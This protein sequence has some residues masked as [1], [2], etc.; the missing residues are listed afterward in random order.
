ML[1]AGG[2][3][4]FTFAVGSTR[5]SVN[6]QHNFWL[7][8]ILTSGAVTSLILHY[9]DGAQATYG[10]YDKSDTSFGG[11]FYVTSMA[12]AAGNQTTF[13]YDLNFHLTTVTAAD[14]TT[15]TLS[16]ND[17]I[18]SDAITSIGTSYG[19]SVSFSY[20]DLYGPILTNITD[21]AGLS[22][23]IVYEDVAGHSVKKLITPYGTTYLSTFGSGGAYGVFDRTVNIT[24]ATGSQEFYGQIN[25]YSVFGTDWPGWATS[26]IPTNTP[27]GTL[28]KESTNRVE[29]NT[30]Y[31]NAQQFVP[32]INTSLGSFNWAA[33]KCSRIRHWL[34]ATDPTY[35]HW[36]TL[37]VEQAPSPDGGTTEGQTTWYD[38]VGKPTGV[39]Y[40]RGTQML[41]SVAARVMP[42]ATTWYQYFVRNTNGLPT[43]LAE[44]WLSSGTVNTRTNNFVYAAN[45]IDLVAW[46]NALGVLT[47]SNMFNAYHQVV[48][49]YDA[50][51]Q[52]TTNGY[53]GTTHLI[54]SSQN[55]AGLVTTYTYN[56]SHQLQQ[57]TD[58]PINRTRS[59][60]W[61][62]DGTMATYTDERGLVETYYSDALHRLTGTSDTR[63]ATTNLYYLVSGIHYPNSS[64]GTAILDLTATKDRMGYWTYYGYDGLRRL[65]AI[66]NA[67][68]VV[69]AYGYCD[70]GAVSYV[71][72]GFGTPVQQAITYTY[73][74]QGNRTIERSRITPMAITSL[75]GSMLYRGGQSQ[76]MVPPIIG[77]ITITSPGSPRS[78]M[79]MAR[80]G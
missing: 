23:Q 48:T 21:A 54:T 10:V 1:P 15:F 7:E 3:A 22:S 6:Y 78:A 35:T 12:D 62:S 57:V 79:P 69:T 60:T 68:N 65:T 61:N 76:A 28:D 30:F 42:D 47:S 49:N 66:T 75:T 29:R 71:T 36:D 2:W 24:N 31:W 11:V 25:D 77:S 13:S 80:S 63:G 38:Y 74:N 73:D 44:V 59:Y 32:F 67:N 51:N 33:F 70:C 52:V 56:T 46:T 20:A 43:Q 58:Q 8:K 27:V 9:P 16:Y 55:P 39:D 40:E 50:L 19:A 4:P 18:Y 17:S 72:N 53:D 34:A 45:N 14:G 64:G 26:Q 37:S 5:S 41:P